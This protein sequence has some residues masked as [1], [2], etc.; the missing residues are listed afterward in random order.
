VREEFDLLREIKETADVVYAEVAAWG[1]IIEGESYLPPARE[2]GNRRQQSRAFTVPAAKADLT[3]PAGRRVRHA[4]R[5]S[6]TR[7]GPMLLAT[8]VVPWDCKR[9]A[10]TF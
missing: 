3:T 7:A 4:S 10:M 8:G 1:L 6:W 2:A 9:Q 5:S